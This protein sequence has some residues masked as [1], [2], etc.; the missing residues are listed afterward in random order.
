MKQNIKYLK[1]WQNVFVTFRFIMFLTVLIKIVCLMAMHNNW[2]FCIILLISQYL[3]VLTSIR[4]MNIKMCFPNWASFEVG[5]QYWA[6]LL[7][8]DFTAFTDNYEENPLTFDTTNT[9]A[10]RIFT[11][12]DFIW[13]W[14]MIKHSSVTAE[15]LV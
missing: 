7:C 8:Y 4:K 2:F 14:A 9:M 1:I 10:L 6:P 5:I 13:E 12:Q 15:A 3:L 11:I